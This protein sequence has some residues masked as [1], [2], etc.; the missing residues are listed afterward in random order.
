[1]IL[2]DILTSFLHKKNIFV[3]AFFM[4]EYFLF[5]EYLGK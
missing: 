1:M 5:V 3:V 4:A 2:F